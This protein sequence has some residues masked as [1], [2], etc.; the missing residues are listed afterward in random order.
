MKKKR[1]NVDI[2]PNDFDEVVCRLLEDGCDVYMEE[3]G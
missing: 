1:I 3:D 2:K